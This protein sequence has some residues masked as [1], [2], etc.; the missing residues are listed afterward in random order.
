M[1]SLIRWQNCMNIWLS[2]F[3]H[4]V[5]VACVRP[6]GCCFSNEVSIWI[7][8][9]HLNKDGGRRG[10]GCPCWNKYSM[11]ET[12][13]DWLIFVIEIMNIHN[14]REG[15]GPP[16]SV[17]RNYQAKITASLSFLRE[18]SPLRKS[19]SIFTD[20]IPAYAGMTA[21]EENGQSEECTL[22]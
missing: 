16:V 22:R 15:R 5:L 18:T 6:L 3:I 2:K 21:W 12:R 7:S 20:W 4:R 9:S 19:A 14:S 13:N 10:H 1:C 11:D 17:V 8:I